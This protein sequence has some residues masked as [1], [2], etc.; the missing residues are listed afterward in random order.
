MQQNR[1]NAKGDEYFCKALYVKD[2]N[3]RSNRLSGNPLACIT[4]HP[5]HKLFQWE[6]LAPSNYMKCWEPFNMN[7][8]IR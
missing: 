6:R 2:N 1:K 3:N 8:L 4:L 7:Q 5:R